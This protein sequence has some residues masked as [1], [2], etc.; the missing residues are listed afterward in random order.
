[1]HGHGP[2]P[3]RS[4]SS[5]HPARPPIPACRRS[6]RCLVDGACPESNP[7]TVHSPSLSLSHWD[8]SNRSG[9]E[10][11]LHIR[12]NNKA[13]S[14]HAISSTPPSRGHLPVWSEAL[15]E[16]RSRGRRDAC[17]AD[18]TG[19]C[20]NAHGCHLPYY[21]YPAARDGRSWSPG[22]RCMPRNRF[23]DPAARMDMDLVRL[24]ARALPPIGSV[25]LPPTETRRR[26]GRCRRRRCV[27]TVPRSGRR[28]GPGAGE[29]W[30]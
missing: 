7:P 8:S 10:E 16:A 22:S 20:A 3:D 25:P 17:T 1:V 27:C 15:S 29:N 23:F 21:Y 18:S 9:P 28:L 30:A 12:P 24:H 13:S 4:S 19:A 26:Y 5:G 6:A 11:Q 14:D 2:G